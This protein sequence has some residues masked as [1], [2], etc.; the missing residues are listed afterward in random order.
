MSSL[1]NSSRMREPDVS[2]MTVE[3]APVLT[4]KYTP[5][6]TS[7]AMSCQKPKSPSRGGSARSWKTA[8]LAPMVSM[9]WPILKAQCTGRLRWMR[10]ASVLATTWVSAAAPM[11]AKSSS[12][13]EKVVDG[14]S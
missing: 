4:T 12:P 8:P 13:K 6:A 2:A 9:Y 11:P 10:S 14:T 5:A 3:T 1:E 7:A